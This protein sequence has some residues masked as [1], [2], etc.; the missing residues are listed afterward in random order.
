[1]GR[2]ALIAM[3]GGVDSSV[4]ALLMQEAGYEPIGVTMKLYNNVDAGMCNAHTCCSLKDIEDARA[5]AGRLGIA[6]YVMNFQD[7]FHE[8]VIDKFALTYLNGATPNPCIDCNKYMKFGTLTERAR[9]FGCEKA[10]TGHY[11]RI[12]KNEKTGEYELH[13]ALDDTKDQ[14]YVLYFLNQ[15]QL[16]YLEFPLGKLKKTQAREIAEKH[17][18]INARKH[19]SQDICFVPDG[20]YARVIDEYL[21]EHQDKYEGILNK[22]SIN[23]YFKDKYGKILGQHNGFYHY[24]IGQR[25]GLGISAT[26]PLYVI[27]INARENVV[28]LG[29]NDDLMKCDVYAYGFTFVSKKETEMISKWKNT[30]I[31]CAAK[32]RYRAKESAG[33]LKIIGKAEDGT[34]NVMMH[35][36]TPVRAVTAGQSLVAYDNTRVIGGGIIKDS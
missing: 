13:K 25:R 5:V 12:E 3:S 24:T 14:S 16:S 8:K 27:S 10:V 31:Q 36:D 18:L 4:A 21:K 35:F 1:M 30:E 23:G 9:E 19:D 29:N 28:I 26:E 15:E 6:H 34:F 33:I 7:G 2:K 17:G 11:V 20:N 32:I 22:K